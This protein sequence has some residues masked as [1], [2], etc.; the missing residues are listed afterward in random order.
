MISEN[1]ILRGQNITSEMRENLKNLLIAVNKFRSIYGKAMIVTSG[2]RSPEHNKAIGGAPNSKHCQCLA[3]DFA[4][5]DGELK[6]FCQKDNYKVL[7]E[8]S[9]WMEASEFCP[10]WLHVTISPPASGH[11][12]FKP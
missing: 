2:Y 12:E 6:R 7:I 1:E 10:S 9:L 8:C 11:R 4:D 3:V 5:Y